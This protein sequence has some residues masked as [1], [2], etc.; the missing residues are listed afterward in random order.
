MG[1]EMT[2]VGLGPRTVR[3]IHSVLRMTLDH[4]GA[5]KKLRGKN[6]V[7]NVRF[8]A[9]SVTSHVY[10]TAAAVAKFAELC[11]TAR[12]ENSRAVKQGDVVVILA[13]TGLRFGEL[14]GLNVEDVE[15]QARRIRVRRSITQLSG[16]LLEGP[17]KSRA[18]RRSVPIPKLLVPILDAGSRGVRLVSR[19]SYRRRVRGWRSKTGSGRWGGGSGSPNSG[20]RPCA[21][22]ISGTP[23]RRLLDRRA[24]TRNCCK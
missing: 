15:L 22:T 24:P 17:P 21:C 3:W 12:G 19:R 23:T 18:G 5:D 4:A 8:P 2:A 7:S 14:T 16:R 9:M 11:D 13:Y 1:Q 6:P 20:V 10:L